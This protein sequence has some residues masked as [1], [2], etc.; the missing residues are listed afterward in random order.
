MYRI[1]A[2]FIVSILQVTNL[3]AQPRIDSLRVELKTANDTLK[4]NLLNELAWEFCGSDNKQAFDYVNQ[5]MEL[6]TAIQFQKGLATANNYKGVILQNT[7]DYDASIQYLKQA[8]LQ[9]LDLNLE[10]SASGCLNNIGV[11]YLYLGDYDKALENFYRALATKEKLNDKQ[12]LSSIYN[13]IGIIHAYH[14]NNKKALEYYLKSL[15]AAGKDSLSLMVANTQ[16]NIALIYEERDELEKSKTY[17]NK[18]L[19]THKLLN[20]KKGMS[21]IYQNLGGLLA[22][23]FFYREAEENYVMALEIDKELGDDESMIRSM[24][25]LA[26]IY[27]K[28][29]KN[30]KALELYQSAFEI[31]LEIGTL[32]QS[33]RVLQSLADFYE[34]QGNKPLAYDYFKQYKTFNDSLFSIESN[35]NITQLRETYEAEKREQEIN[36]LSL[37]SELQDKALKNQRFWLLMSILA[38]VV[39][40]ALWMIVLVQRNQKNR[41][42]KDLVRKNLEN[43]VIEKKL[44]QNQKIEIAKTEIEIKEQHNQQRYKNSQLD[45][46]EKH[47]ILRKLS[48]LMENDKLFLKSDLTIEMVASDLNTNKRYISQVINEVLKQNFSSYLNE[49]R[50]KEARELLLDAKHRH[51]TIE[52]VAGMVGFN[53]KSAFNNSFK[54]FTGVTPSFFIKNAGEITV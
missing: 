41:A 23:E 30:S 36:Q 16:N 1:I 17:F 43:V 50:I 31:S 48:K 9:Y 8:Y 52:S 4:V 13:N 10:S 15:N 38:V 21:A 7:G 47:K 11:T 14:Q 35:R 46:T 3:F 33:V 6:S 54:K 20:N 53:S 5:A 18:S 2:V 39:F 51:L 28:Q 42:Y 45:H 32:S 26:D 24:L 27:F 22:E 12:A 49:Y 40:A 29:K 25:G 44:K 34:T 37:K 19:E